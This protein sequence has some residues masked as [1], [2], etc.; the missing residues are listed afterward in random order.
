MARL[1]AIAFLLLG[2]A[3]AMPAAALIMN[4]ATLGWTL[5]ASSVLLG[6]FGA[7]VVRAVALQSSGMVIMNQGGALTISDG[8]STYTLYPGG[9]VLVTGGRT[10]ITEAD[11]PE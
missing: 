10:I 8:R 9:R 2:G 3:G 6:L 1:Q 11:A 5:A 4:P 7:L